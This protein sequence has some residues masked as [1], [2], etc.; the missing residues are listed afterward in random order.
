MVTGQMTKKDPR[1]GFFVVL[2]GKLYYRSMNLKFW[3]KKPDAIGGQ[4]ETA[5][6]DYLKHRGYRI[7]ERNVRNQKGRQMGEIDIV[8]Q[9]GEMIVFVEVKTSHMGSAGASRPDSRI[10]PAK[11]RRLE[12]TANWYV[13]ERQLLDCPYRFDAIS[14][15]VGSGEKNLSITHLE[16]IF[17]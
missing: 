4:G 15:I 11:L 2:G 12:K 6:A 7:L 8:A 13:R 1:A 10:T 14:V 17:L 5:A 3:R 16:S 9:H